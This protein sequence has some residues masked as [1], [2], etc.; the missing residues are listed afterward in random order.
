MSSTSHSD[1][2]SGALPRDP[3]TDKM[4][5][6]RALLPGEPARGSGVRCTLMAAHD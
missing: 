5:Q 1:G 3:P 6:I 2:N 4:G